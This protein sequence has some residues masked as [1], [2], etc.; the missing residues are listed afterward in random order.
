AKPL[1][2][3]SKV[4]MGPALL[5]ED[6]SVGADGVVHATIRFDTAKRRFTVA[7]ATELRNA[8]AQ[9]REGEAIL[10]YFEPIGQ[11]LLS[12]GKVREALQSYRDLI[13]QHPKE[14]VHHLQLAE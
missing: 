9:Q 7:E 3:N 6:F 2:K 11:A 1:P 14:A 5:T 13:A 4:A 12:Q 8:V 10:I